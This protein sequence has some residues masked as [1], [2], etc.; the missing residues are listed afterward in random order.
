MCFPHGHRQGC[1][2]RC[3]HMAVVQSLL[4]VPVSHPP[5]CELMNQQWCLVFFVNIN[6]S[7]RQ[8]THGLTSLLPLPPGWCHLVRDSSDSAAM[9]A[10]PQTWER[11][12][13]EQIQHFFLRHCHVMKDLQITPDLHPQHK[14]CCI[15]VHCMSTGQQH[16]PA[17]TS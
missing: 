5:T 13:M 8:I 7:C 17:L 4:F 15:L 2:A 10:M 1:T 9:K 3:Q 14:H 6:T 16:L 12:Q 11:H